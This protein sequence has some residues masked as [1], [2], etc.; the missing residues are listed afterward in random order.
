MKIDDMNDGRQFA[1]SAGRNIDPILDVLSRHA[2]ASGRALEIASGT[3]QHMARLTA[4]FPGL[5][6]Q[7]TDLDPLRMASI[8]A[9]RAHCGL[10]NFNAPVTMDASQPWPDEFG[11]LSLV[12]LVNV[13]HLIADAPARAILRNTAQAVAT[14]GIFTIYGPFKR[15][16][17][18]ASDADRAFDH[19]LRARDP[20]TGYK[21]I[22][23]VE[24]TLR[25][26]GFDIVE[27]AQMPAS[28][29]MVVSR[30]S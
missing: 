28:N 27:Q 3:G 29:L 6:W 12:C 16:E 10:S 17:A 2:P 21:T 18:F 22:V 15:G 8:E 13:L 5:T 26:C 4:K 7:P 24:D 11:G 25:D 14:G 9:W 20:S 30:K 23:W 1:P 19:D